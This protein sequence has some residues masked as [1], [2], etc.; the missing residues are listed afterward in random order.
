VPSLV[1]IEVHVYFCLRLM[2]KPCRGLFE[3]RTY[4]HLA[5]IT[6]EASTLTYALVSNR[7]TVLKRVKK[8]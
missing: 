2:L 6:L 7:V 5:S 4:L 1:L 3:G 8:Y